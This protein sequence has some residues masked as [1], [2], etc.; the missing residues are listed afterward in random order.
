MNIQ[1][2]SKRR[3]MSGFTLIEAIVAVAILGITMLPIM[4][5][6]GQSITQLTIA[7]EAN[8]RAAATETALAVIDPVNPLLTPS[9]E[10]QIGDTLLVWDSEILV[11]P[12]ETPQIRAGL[13]GYRIGFYKVTISLSKD[14]TPW[15]SFD[16]RK[17]GYQRFSIEGTPFEA[18]AR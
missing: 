15:F 3:V 6:L 17:V 9:G 12:N 13:A 11:N 16:T 4:A 14:D 7:G 2:N 5:L 10:T 8:A 18:T 1:G